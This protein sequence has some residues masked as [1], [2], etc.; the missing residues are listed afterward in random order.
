ME[1]IKYLEDLISIKSYDLNENA[2][3]INYLE[4]QFSTIS[5]EIIKIKNENDSRENLLIGINTQL[6]NIDNAIILAG[7]ID[8][9]VADEISYKTNPYI[10][11][12]IDNKIYGLGAID[13]KS[14]FAIILNNLKKLSEIKLPIIVAITS[15]EETKL[16]SVKTITSLLKELK[17]SPKLSIIGEPTNCKICCSSKSCYEY[18]IEIIGKSCHSSCPQL[19]INANYIAAKLIL[20]I[21]KLCK[22]YK[23]ATMSSNL[24][25]GG[26]KVNIISSYCKINFDIRAKNAKKAT[27]ILKKVENFAK[28]LEKRYLGAKIFIKNKLSILPLENKNSNL[29]KKFIQKF[30]LNETEFLGGCEAG[31]YQLVGGDAIVFG[32]GDL[33]LAH[34]PNEF[35]EINE[36][37]KYSEL[38]IKIINYVQDE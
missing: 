6:K 23:K 15:D 22:K 26:E 34:K 4:K 29:V 37:L 18:E 24:I 38:L 8:T 14:F 27:K 12:K 7:H 11:T 17:I 20:F 35:V 36:F 19:G 5:K 25:I 32:V 1:E 3:I 33:S 16:S 13:M 31:Y 10:P 30:D 28:K 2:K 21:E 9:V